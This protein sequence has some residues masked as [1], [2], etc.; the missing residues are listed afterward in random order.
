MKNKTYSLLVSP[1]DE[2]LRVDQFLGST[3]YIKNR[4]Q[5][6]KLIL[7]NHVTSGGQVLKA[8][9]K[10]TQGDRL[11]V[12]IPQENQEVQGYNLP[13]EIVYE[14]EDLLV[15]N[16]P[17]G[18]VVHPAPG[19]FSDTLLHALFYHK[20]IQIDSASSRSGVVHRLDKDTSGLLVLARNK[21]AEENLKEQFKN[22][23]VQRL[24]WAL[25][26]RPPRALNS[27]IKS[28]LCRH[29][30]FRTKYISVQE[31]K[32]GCK[33][34][35]TH[36]KTIKSYNNGIT[37]LECRLETGR[38]H[39]IRVHLSSQSC[40]LLGDK[41]YGQKLKTKS[42]QNL[43]KNLKGTALLAQSLSFTHPKTR[44]AM[45]FKCS[46]PSDLQDLINS[47]ELE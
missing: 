26:L 35:I 41:I 2:G 8:S 12:V 27:T 34:A 17:A 14:D 15:I 28:Y 6:L 44:K 42:I 46:W 29:P 32:T 47:L 20:K 40:P 33:E 9:Y 1:E 13:L 24:Y 7:E 19:H 43:C 36:C 11:D 30:I 3:K 5:A 18:L 4:S 31:Y 23:R 16:K 21:T 45:S 39:Q 38:T 25:S 10:L 22:R 37:W